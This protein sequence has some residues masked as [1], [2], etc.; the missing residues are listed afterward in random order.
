MSPQE[1]I[2]SYLASADAWKST[3]LTNLRKHIHE[4]D[5]EIIEEWKWDV[6]VFTHN[7]MVC[8]ISCFKDHVKINF[9]KGAKL[10]DPYK[11]I[12]AGFESKSHRSID[13]H[14]G[15]SLNEPALLDL[16]KEAVL[17]NTKK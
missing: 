1:K 3:V 16:I 8:A 13:F 9:F 17:H 15:D 12:N 7:G 2:D 4:A 5:P 14:E 11:I 6:P 10:S